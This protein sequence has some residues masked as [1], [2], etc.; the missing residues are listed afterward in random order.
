M[1]NNSLY[2]VR[3]IAIAAG[4]MIH[5]LLNAQWPQWCGQLR[6]GASA[7]KLEVVPI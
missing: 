1:K 4:L 6:D 7:E 2:M 5:H 3:R